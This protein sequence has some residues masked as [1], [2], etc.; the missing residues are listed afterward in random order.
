MS[1]IIKKQIYSKLILILF[2]LSIIIVM[3]SMIEFSLRVLKIPEIK[4]G[5]YI[6]EWDPCFFFRNRRNLDIKLFN[7]KIRVTINSNGFRYQDIPLEKSK[8]LFRICCLG[9]S[10][11]FGYGVN[12]EDAF[13]SVLERKLNNVSEKT[14]YEV[15]NC[16]VVG[17]YSL[18]GLEMFKRDILPFKPDMIIVSY[19]LNDAGMVWMWADMKGNNYKELP[20]PSRSA[21]AVRNYFFPRSNLYRLV[22]KSLYNLRQ[23]IH[24]YFQVR[25]NHRS[26]EKLTSR[27]DYK[28]N[29]RSFIRLAEKHK[30]KV[31][32]FFA[33]VQIIW[34][35]GGK[36]IFTSKKE[37]FDKIK[38]IKLKIN[39]QKVTNYINYFH[40]GNCC[41]YLNNQKLARKYY[42][43]AVKCEPSYSIWRKDALEFYLLMKKVARDENIPFI[44]VNNKFYNEEYHHNSKRLFFDVYHTSEYGHK[45]IADEIFQILSIRKL[46]K[47]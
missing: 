10:T 7:N 4:P 16:G 1:N 9:D 12:N 14:K 19:A 27:S 2:T 37:C 23:N 26:A 34:A 36:I 43:E 42:Y 47:Y 40:L 13:T 38:E 29:L 15:I 28:N 17:Q 11:T 41:Q 33:P 20:R 18:S 5:N 35:E 45:I 24:Y 39:L 21:V 31:I 25:N 8:N 3:V 6:L 44:D 30:I 32:F 46:V 22:S